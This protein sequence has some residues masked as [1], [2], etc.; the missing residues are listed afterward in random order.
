MTLPRRAIAAA[1]IVIGAAAGWVFI[2]PSR[3]AAQPIAFNHARHQAL[4]CAG[5]HRGVE[6]A[7]RAMLPGPDVCAKCHAAAPAGVTADQWTAFQRA[8]VNWVTLT[9]IPDHSLFSHQRHVT[10]GHLECSSCHGDIGQR[11]AP[12][13]RAPIR[14]DMKT[15]RACHQQEGA[16]EDC[17]AC[18][19]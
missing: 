13:G 15:C 8:A 6:V 14:L 1:G 9:R 12:P 7:A 17:A 5:C 4:T 10:L 19:R 2:L 11:T 18:H 16:S 3:P